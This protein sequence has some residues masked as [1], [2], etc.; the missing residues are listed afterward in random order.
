MH[1]YPLVGQLLERPPSG[2]ATTVSSETRGV[3]PEPLGT[4]AVKT[5]EGMVFLNLRGV[6]RGVKELTI[7][8]EENNHDH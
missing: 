3:P 4:Y 6:K 1:R 8:I 5:T 7:G 2:D